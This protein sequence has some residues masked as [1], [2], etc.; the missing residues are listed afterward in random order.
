MLVILACFEFFQFLPQWT[1]VGLIAYAAIY[2]GGR[3]F[4]GSAQ[5]WEA[6]EVL[7]GT[8][9]VV[10]SSPRDAQDPT[11]NPSIPNVHRAADPQAAIPAS[12]SRDRAGLRDGSSLPVI[13]RHG[14]PGTSAISK[15]PTCAPSMPSE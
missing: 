14:S 15:T 9:E 1:A 8:A 12:G 4:R 7:V 5:I 3:P 11:G 6:A 10:R 2:M 13:R